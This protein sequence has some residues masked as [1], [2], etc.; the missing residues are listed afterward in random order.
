MYYI[1]IQIARF[2][3]YYLGFE[4]RTV[5]KITNCSNI[6]QIVRHNG[7]SGEITITLLC[8]LILLI[9]SGEGIK[10]NLSFSSQS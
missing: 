6:V 4:S 10:F 2:Q 5:I 1:D 9:Q 8:L 7:V 3:N